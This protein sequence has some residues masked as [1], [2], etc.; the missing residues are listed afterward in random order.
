MSTE[1]ILFSFRGRVPRKI[2]WLYGVLGPL[3]GSA[4]GEMLLGIAGVNE[5][6]SDLA[7]SLLFAWPHAAV[8][9]KRWHDRGKSG[10]WILLNL[11]PLIGNVWS[12]VETGLLRGTHGDNRFGP[13]LTDQ[14]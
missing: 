13:D 14:F 9:V 6:R 11:I 5:H 10:W 4:I 12:L 3:L 7:M 8:A 2:Y 1:Q